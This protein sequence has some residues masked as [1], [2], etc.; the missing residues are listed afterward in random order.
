M[1]KVFV[2][3]DFLTG[4]LDVIRAV[5]S[6]KAAADEID[7]FLTG[8]VRKKQQVWIDLVENDGVT[9]RLRDHDLQHPHAMP[10]RTILERA[11]GD[12]EVEKG[13]DKEAIRV[14]ATRCYLCN[15][16]FEIDQD[17]C[18]HCAWCI[19]AAPRD[20]IKKVSRI[21]TRSDGGPPDYVAT[22]R[23]AEATYIYID[24]DNCIRCGKCVRA[25]PTDAISMR[26]M[27]RTAYCEIKG[28]SRRIE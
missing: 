25:C 23:A 15:Y 18:I 17:K 19:D 10:L 26:R 20:C 11:T 27:T 7:R 1:P 22:D 12:V 8:E 3:G 16:K 9:G 6:G 4:S 13:L 21:F 5:S 2:A 28:A 24:S 14:A